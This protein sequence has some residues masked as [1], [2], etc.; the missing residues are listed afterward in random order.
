MALG[1]GVWAIRIASR[2][3][4]VAMMGDA[5][6]EG[7]HCRKVMRLVAVG[8]G[9]VAL[10]LT[11]LNFP[12]EVYQYLL[13]GGFLVLGYFALALFSGNE[14]YEISYAK[15][16]VGG[17][18]FAFGTTLT[19]HVYLLSMGIGEMIRSKEFLCFAVLC[20]LASAATELWGHAARTD[21]TETKASHELALSLPLTLLG[22]AAL[23]FAVKNDSMAT[24]PFYYAILTGAALLQVL[25][26]TRGRFSIGTLK[27]MAGG[28]LIIPGV[29]FE[30][31]A[32]NR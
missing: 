5:P 3:L 6:P 18:A 32:L 11:V 12:R 30:A 17:V 8:A 27:V 15:H 31:Y 26:K 24:R 20:L 16:L 10:V 1:F 2:L 21:D 13:V 4:E 28:C 7:E 23:V 14:E 22:A 19:A 9:L 25:N 29:V